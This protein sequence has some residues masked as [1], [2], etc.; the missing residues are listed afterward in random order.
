M[1]ASTSRSPPPYVAEACTARSSSFLPLQLKRVRA[2]TPYGD[3][4]LRDS[5]GLRAVADVV[6]GCIVVPP[7]QL[8]QPRAVEVH[9]D[10]H[11]FSRVSYPVDALIIG[12]HRRGPILSAPR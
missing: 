1:P 6:A 9:A 10:R 8:P 4:S 3:N 2:L 7:V 5:S 12:Q 11:R